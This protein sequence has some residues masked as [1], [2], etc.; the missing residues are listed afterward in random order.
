VPERNGIEVWFGHRVSDSTD[1]GVGPDA[2]NTIAPS[3]LA[4]WLDARKGRRALRCADLTDGATR[5]TGFLLSFDD[6]YRDNLT[7]ALPVL[8]ARDV[9]VLIFVTTGF[10]GGEAEPA[11]DVIARLVTIRHPLRAARGR[12]YDCS[13]DEARRRSYE[14]IRRRIKACGVAERDRRLAELRR[15]NDDPGAPEGRRFLCW[16]ELR[17][18]DRHPL[19]TIGAHSHTHPLLTR[20][21]RAEAEREIRESQTALVR[22]LGHPVT[23]FAYPYGGHD[24]R[25][26]RAVAR[27]GFGL[28]FTT[29]PRPLR[30]RS[31]RRP[32]RLPRRDLAQALREAVA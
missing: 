1:G 30:P 25:V 17:Q 32:L 19:V 29:E 23:A 10:V 4:A 20:A 14:E 28:A 31:L 7:E 24:R 26:R 21:T 13:D 5:P 3:A 9:P 18:L 8:E 12:E 6:G 27:A 11:E 16:E 2:R 15:L 22:E